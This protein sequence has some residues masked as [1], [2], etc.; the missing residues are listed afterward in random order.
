MVLL[1]LFG[2]VTQDIGLVVFGC[3]VC[4]LGVVF[5]NVRPRVRP[6]TG[7]TVLVATW[8]LGLAMSVYGCG[9]VVAAVGAIGSELFLVYLI[10]GGVSWL[11]GGA[12]FVATVWLASR[13]ETSRTTQAPFMAESIRPR[14]RKSE[15]PQENRD[16]TENRGACLRTERRTS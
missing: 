6:I 16:M 12:L 7:W 14:E 13:S 1:A 11:G 8:A 9:Y 4:V 3:A 10:T 15:S 5:V 2:L